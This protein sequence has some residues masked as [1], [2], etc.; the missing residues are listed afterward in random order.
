MASHVHEETFDAS[1]DALFEHSP[2]GQ[3]FLQA[4]EKGWRDTFADI[5]RY[6]SA[7]RDQ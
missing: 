7:R 2:G 1:A 3:E 4:C 6:L 5:R